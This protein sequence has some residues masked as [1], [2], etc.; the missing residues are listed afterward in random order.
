[1]GIPVNE[2]LKITNEYSQL[3]LEV[4]GEATTEGTRIE[5]YTDTGKD[6]QRWRL[7][8]AGP[9]SEGFYNIENV[10]S[11]HEPRSRQLQ[12]RT[13]SRDRPTAVWDWSPASSME[14]GRGGWEN[15]CVQ[16]LEP[17]QRT[18]ARRR[19]W[20]EGGSGTGQ[21]VRVVERR[22]TSTVA[23][24]HRTGTS[25][26]HTENWPNYRFAGGQWRVSQ[27]DQPWY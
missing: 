9:G 10:H 16:D 2:T 5:Q 25:N 4:E 11:N 14:T 18:R 22:R 7:K 8:P 27:P 23:A 19:R 26:L 1:M 3:V 17:E 13:W 20:A 12:Y 21:T 15:G 24:D 6:H